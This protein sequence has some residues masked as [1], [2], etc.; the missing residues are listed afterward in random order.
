MRTNY[1]GIIY[2]PKRRRYRVRLYRGRDVAH[3]SYHRTLD[4]AMAAYETAQ[5]DR[6]PK[7]R[8]PQTFNPNDLIAFLQGA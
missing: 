6:T 4:D 3:L 7:T 2:D 5:R 1:T 8:P